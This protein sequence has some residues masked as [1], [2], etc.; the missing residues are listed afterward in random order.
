MPGESVPA[1]STSSRDATYEALDDELFTLTLSHDN[2]KEL[3]GE[4]ISKL[5]QS[6]DQSTSI[7]DNLNRW[8]SAD[9]ARFTPRSSSTILEAPFRLI[10]PKSAFPSFEETGLYV[11]QY[12]AISYCWHSDEFLP[13]GYERHGSW[14]IR[15]QFVDAILE[16]K[17]HPREGIWMDQ[18]CIDQSDP[19]NKGKSIASMD[20]IYRSCIRLVV[21]LE[22]V[23]LDEQEAA[24]HAKYDLTEM[25]Y[26]STWTPNGENRGT[27]AS[28]YHKV[29]ATRW[30]K[31]AWCLHEFSVN[32]PWTDN[33]Q[34]NRVHNATFIL[35]GPNGSTVKIKWF[36]LQLMM[37]SALDISPS[38]TINILTSFNGQYIFSA[39]ERGIELDDSI[40]RRS[41]MARHFGVNRQGSTY[42]ADRLSVIMNMCGIGLAYVGPE[43]RTEHE[44][45]YFSILLAL[46]SGE[47]YPLTIFSSPSIL[48][49]GKPTW[50]A[51]GV[52]PGDTSIPKFKLRDDNGIYSVSMENIELDIFFNFAWEQV[53]DEDLT[54]TYT[55]FSDIISTTQPPRKD[56]DAS[57]WTTVLDSSDTFLDPCRRHF[58]AGCIMNG[59]VFTAG[60]WA[61]LKRD[62]VIPNYNTG[63]FKDLVPNPSFHDAA[64]KFI[65]QLLPISSLLCIPPSQ[66]F[67]LADAHLFLTWLTDPRSMYYIG[68]YT[69]S[70]PS[71]LEGQRA[72]VPG[73]LINEHL[74][75]GPVEELKLAVPT[76]LLRTTCM[77]YRVW[78]LRPGKEGKWRL[79]AKALLMGEPDL[80]EEASRSSEEECAVVTLSRVV[81]SGPEIASSK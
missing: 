63:M 56:I 17:D 16:D 70:L 33:R 1:P 74:K 42:L 31:R 21:L 39:V 47:F 77:H 49:D 2:K 78:I 68:A 61:Q 8:N 19:I 73:W 58:L 54:S 38:G 45:L 5:A 20:I 22:D 36:D 62:V 25:I 41:I 81:V 69:Y 80:L 55:I 43:L 4:A 13:E 48:S 76:D 6:N 11:R 9:A 29:N 59:Y 50:L 79:V 18:I 14:P 3:F 66:D 10:F 37:G 34:G 75:D 27:Y 72:F 53:K 26:K 71:T 30:W 67:T 15:K 65:T 24:L 12:I 28:F 57:S 7:L 32:D 44:V 40:S 46:A 51:R 23:F 60:L 35:N 64:W 52:G